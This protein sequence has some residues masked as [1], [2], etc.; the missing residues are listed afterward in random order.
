VTDDR[1]ELI[2][3][4]LR[5][6]SQYVREGKAELV[7]EVDAELRRLGAAGLTPR[8]RATRLDVPKGTR[9]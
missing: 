9:L 3:N 5:E 8:Q 1:H 7:A 6:R 4:L 2:E